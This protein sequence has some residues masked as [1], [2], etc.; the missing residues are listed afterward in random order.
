MKTMLLE[1]P[2][3]LSEADRAQVVAWLA[4]RVEWLKPAELLS[5]DDLATWNALLD[6]ENPAWLG[7]R[8]DLYA[9][10]ARSVHI[11]RKP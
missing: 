2:V 5:D 3:P 6:P 7:H 9:I 4:H 8:D 11:G 1:R 10:E